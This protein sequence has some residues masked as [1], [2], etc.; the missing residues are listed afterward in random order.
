MF[1]YKRTLKL[2]SCDRIS[3]T[4]VFQRIFKGNGINVY[5]LKKKNSNIIDIPSVIKNT[6]FS[7]TR[8]KRKNT[9]QM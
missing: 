1:I 2:P 9:R 4:E 6:P 3:N 7:E 8:D 5:H